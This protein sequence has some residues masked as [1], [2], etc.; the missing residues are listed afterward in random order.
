[1][2]VDTDITP[3]LTNPD[4]QRSRKLLES[5]LREINYLLSPPS[6][7][8]DKAS[9]SQ[10]WP[11]NDSNHALQQARPEPASSEEITYVPVDNETRPQEEDELPRKVP[12]KVSLLAP[13]PTEPLS[14]PP[15]KEEITWDFAPHENKTT[16]LER[17]QASRPS[18][19]T[20][21]FTNKTPDNPKQFRQ[22]HTLKSHLAPVRALIPINS[23]NALLDETCFASAGDDSLIKFWRVSKTSNAT[24]VLKK[25]GNFDILPQVTYRGHSGIIT[26]L[27]ESLGNIWSGG[28]DGGIRGWRLPSQSRDAYG[29]SGPQTRGSVLT[30]SGCNGDFGVRGSYKLYLEFVVSRNTATSSCIRRRRRDCK[31]M[32]YEI[33]FTK[34]ITC[35]V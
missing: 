5:C 2:I 29:S 13:P 28:T 4:R 27:A 26:C 11:N 32:G 20:T 22:I 1:M 19:R 25:K 6:I 31:N 8:I 17:S 14:L 7:P 3:L 23:S 30:F 12:K 33:A 24:N 35:I 21:S 9:Q 15:K 34:S 10:D 16:I 18:V